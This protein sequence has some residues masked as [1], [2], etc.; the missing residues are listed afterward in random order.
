[1]KKLGIILTVLL[2]MAFV[3]CSNPSSSSSNEEKDDKTNNNQTVEYACSHCCIIT[4]KINGI[5]CFRYYGISGILN[6]EDYSN[7]NEA[8]TLVE[9]AYKNE[10]ILDYIFYY[11]YYNTGKPA[12]SGIFCKNLIKINEAKDTEEVKNDYLKVFPSNDGKLHISD[13]KIN[14][15]F[16]DQFKCYKENEDWN[17]KI[18]EINIPQFYLNN[19]GANSFN[20]IDGEIKGMLAVEGKKKNGDSEPYKFEFEDNTYKEVPVNLKCQYFVPENIWENK[21]SYI[22]LNSYKYNIEF[23]SKAGNE[24]R[25]TYNYEINLKG[26]SL[27]PE[28]L[29]VTDDVIFQ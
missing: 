17:F 14:F 16:K 7:N 3:S 8:K 6:N 29:I 9:T 24:D 11:D 26:L 25:R 4:Y 12:Y 5:E 19:K 28:K 10:D 18:Q 1:M 23:I 15:C 21:T 2:T 20:A 27:L 13:I 22:N